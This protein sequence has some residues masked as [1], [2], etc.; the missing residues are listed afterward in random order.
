[1]VYG[2][3][4]FDSPEATGDDAEGAEE[5]HDSPYFP[6]RSWLHN[7]SLDVTWTDIQ[8]Q[9]PS[10]TADRLRSVADEHILFFWASSAFFEI[11]RYT[12]PAAGSN[13]KFVGTHSSSRPADILDGHGDTVGMMEK[14]GHWQQAGALSGRHEFVALGR[15]DLGIEEL[16][17]LYP[18]KII[19]MQIGWDKGV[20]YRVNIAEIEQAAWEAAQ[21]TWKLIALM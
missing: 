11:D 14:M 4:Q 12:G 1:M 19:A 21:P 20:A 18:P 13:R 2:T 8:Q 6:R 9:L 5:Q 10:M 17:D 7:K 3:N 16:R 15:Q